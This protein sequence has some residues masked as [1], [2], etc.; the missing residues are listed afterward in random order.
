MRWR[1][2]LVPGTADSKTAPGLANHSDRCRAPWPPTPPTRPPPWVSSNFLPAVLLPCSRA[3]GRRRLSPARA[4]WKAGGSRPGPYH[5][6][7]PEADLIQRQMRRSQNR[8]WACKRS[9]V[10]PTAGSAHPMWHAHGQFRQRLPV[11]L[12][13][14]LPSLQLPLRG[15]I[16]PLPS[17]QPAHRLG[18]GKTPTPQA[19]ARCWTD[20]P[21]GAG[22]APHAKCC[23]PR[24]RA[25]SAPSCQGSWPCPCNRLPASCRSTSSLAKACWQPPCQPNVPLTGAPASI[26]PGVQAQIGLYLSP[27]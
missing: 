26:I 4:G 27:G 5:R 12:P 24:V 16:G 15:Q 7:I 17:D 11:Q 22:L 13:L 6:Q 21:A 9:G 18:Q 23:S 14:R 25:V 10:H 2:C 3:A 19:E 20:F 1:Q 8:H